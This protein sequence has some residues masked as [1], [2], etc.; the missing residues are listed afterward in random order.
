MS[1]RCFCDLCGEEIYTPADRGNRVSDRIR[2]ELQEVRVE[3]MVGFEGTMNNGHVCTP[4]VIR[5]VNEG[6]DL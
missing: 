3:V 6:A 2:R 5:V 1:T 4:C